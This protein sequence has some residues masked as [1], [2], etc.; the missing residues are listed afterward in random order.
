LPEDLERIQ[1]ILDYSTLFDFAEQN[2]LASPGALVV[3]RGRLFRIPTLVPA[4]NAHGWCKFFDGKLCKIHSV[5]PFGCAFFDAHQEQSESNVISAK[6]L[7][8]IARLW[9]EQPY[10]AYCRIWEELDRRG[11]Q[12]PSPE[13]CRARMRKQYRK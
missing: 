13:E 11:L 3:Q 4:R 8:I 10:A 7:E 5:A 6:G 9:E 12:A 2:L 1:V